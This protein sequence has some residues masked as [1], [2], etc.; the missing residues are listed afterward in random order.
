M[1]NEHSLP[2]NPKNNDQATKKHFSCQTKKYVAIPKTQNLHNPFLAKLHE[3]LNQILICKNILIA[4]VYDKEG[5]G[6]FRVRW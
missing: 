2:V 1:Y 3:T 5:F 6:S 4:K